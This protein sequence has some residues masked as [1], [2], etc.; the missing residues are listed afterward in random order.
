MPTPEAP[1]SV[2]IVNLLGASYRR[3]VYVDVVKALKCVE[4][5][6]SLCTLA[7]RPCLD[8]I[9]SLHSNRSFDLRAH[10]LQWVTFTD[11]TSSLSLVSIRPLDPFVLPVW[12]DSWAHPLSMLQAVTCGSHAIATVVDNSSS[13]LSSFV[14][15]TGCLGDL[16]DGGEEWCGS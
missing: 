16:P 8:V 10:V 11:D 4:R 15:H 1:I 14:F 3:L 13:V 5:K 2:T 6:S 7:S 9:R 12:G